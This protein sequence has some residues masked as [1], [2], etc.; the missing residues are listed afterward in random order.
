[1]TGPADAEVV[2]GKVNAALA[3]RSQGAGW[4]LRA[5]IGI[6]VYPE[7]GADAKT[8]IAHADAAMYRAKKRES[9]GFVFHRAQPL[10]PQPLTL[11]DS[12]QRQTL[13]DANETLVLAALGAQEL[14]DAANDSRR[15]Q[16]ELLLRMASELSDSFSPVRLAAS[17][18]GIEGAEA[19]LLPQV[20]VAIAE[21]AATVARK[22]R[23]ILEQQD[24]VMQSRQGRVQ[25]S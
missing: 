9:S 3:A 12:L 22:V 10:S 20:Q 19:T 23:Q 13:R 1:M 18:V 14:L 24:P 2:A 5:S 4:Q 25:D 17:M 6:S 8:L 16:S 11:T 15:R 21:Q 7:D